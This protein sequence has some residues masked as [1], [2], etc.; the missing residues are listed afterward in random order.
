[1]FGIIAAV[2]FGVGLILDLGKAHIGNA[3][4][5][6]FILAGLLALALNGCS[7]GKSLRG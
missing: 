7:F 1:M 3:T 5:A 4:G 6:T 2:L